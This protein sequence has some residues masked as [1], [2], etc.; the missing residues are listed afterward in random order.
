[1][2][3]IAGEAGL[4]PEQVWDSA[5]IPD[6]ELFLGQASG[7]AMPLVWAHAEYLK[8]CRSL[9]DGQVFDQPPQTVQRYLVQQTTSDRIVWRFNN[10]VR[11][12]PA[13]RTLRV[14]TLV[15][16]VVHWSVDGWHTVHDTATRDTT[17]GVHVADV[18]T[19][20]LRCGEHVDLT[21]YWPEAGRWEGI[22]FQVCIE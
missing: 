1:M 4:L 20:D 22:N 8:L 10:K 13:N 12:M 19:R 16:A 15:P 7:S 5:D 2:E 18:G 21:F 6:R 14:E 17:L 11:A 9:F 3:T